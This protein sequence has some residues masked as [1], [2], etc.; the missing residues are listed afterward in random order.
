M[1][2]HDL[3]ART[4]LVL[5]TN[6]LRGGADLSK[7]ANSLRRLFVHLREQSLSL[8]TLAQLVVTHDGLPEAVQADLSDA[9]GRHLDFVLI[10][11]STGYYTAK[12]AG[13]AATRSE[14]CE[15]V[16]FAD[17]DCIPADDWLEQLLLPLCAE[18]PP[19]V[20][21][22][23]TSYSTSL[24]GTALTTLDFMYFPSPLQAGATRNFYANNVVF[25]RDV[26]AEHAYQ[27]LDGVYRA[28]CQVLGLNLQAA[29]IALHYAA[30][31]HT[32][33]RL[34]DTR[35]EALKLRWMRGQDSVGLT[36]YLVRAYLP[37]NL[38]WFARS[39]P[40]APLVILIARLGFSLRA[41]NHQ[42]LPP[43]RG[44][45][46]LGAMGLILGFSLVD[47]LGALARGIG[48]NTLGRKMAADAQA[49]SYHRA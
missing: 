38:H 43:L 17:A 48:I 18:Q 46:R 8:A 44:V 49:L 9:A 39:G 10:N 37:Q 33:H 32:E 30:G 6:N 16:V 22:G 1:N 15:H 24:A 42:D 31:A 26:F 34:P 40:L 28:H 29:G 21:A 13:F 20:V 12:N 11:V 2:L 4:A 47:M 35:G 41:L 7:V 36:P 14:L 27:A 5:E 3:A 25:R 23:R 45:R 19:A